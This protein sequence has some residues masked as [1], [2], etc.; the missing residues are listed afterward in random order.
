MLSVDEGEGKPEAVEPRP[1]PAVVQPEGPHPA[2]VQPDEPSS[3]HDPVPASASGPASPARAQAETA[4]VFRVVDERTHLP[5]ETFEVSLGRHFLRPLLD[6]KGR[7]RLDFPEGRVRFPGVIEAREGETV[8]LKVKARGF[9]D[10]RI[11][12]F[13]V[14]PGQEL[15]LGTLRL[16]RAP[17]LV[18]RV[19]DDESGEP[20][21]G[22]R[23]ALIVAHAFPPSPGYLDPW[24]ASTDRDGQVLLTS[25]PGEP[26]RIQVRH[27]AYAALDEEILLPLAD[28][29]EKSVRLVKRAEK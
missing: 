12:E 28:E 27:S 16:Q 20:V 3:V 4:L 15:D 7:I 14:N 19:L 23:V 21:T 10:L 2:G 11:S 17:R 6:D 29:H 13:Y 22:A 9:E 26:G 8:N 18:V 5:L 24:S 1:Q 25:R